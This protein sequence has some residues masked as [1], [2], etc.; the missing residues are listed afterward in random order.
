MKNE[1]EKVSLGIQRIRTVKTTK[2]FIQDQLAMLD[3]GFIATP[4]KFEHL[5]AFAKSNQGNSDFLLMQMAMQ[6]GMK[7]ALDLVATELEK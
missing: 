6:Y 4:E 3:R 1:T 2:K 7:L 5:E